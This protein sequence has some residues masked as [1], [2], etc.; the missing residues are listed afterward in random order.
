MKK[1][2]GLL[3]VLNPFY[4]EVAQRHY[5]RG[6]CLFEVLLAIRNRFKPFVEITADA[7]DQ[8]ED[9][10]E[11]LVEAGSDSNMIIDHLMEVKVN[12]SACGRPDDFKEIMRRIHDFSTEANVEEVYKHV[13]RTWFLDTADK[14]AFKYANAGVLDPPIIIEPKGLPITFEVPQTNTSS[15]NA[16][17]IARIALMLINAGR[18][19]RGMR[20]LEVAER[21]AKASHHT[22]AE[23]AVDDGQFPHN[24]TFALCQCAIG[25]VW[26]KRAQHDKAV[27]YFHRALLH[28]RSSNA[29]NE[30]SSPSPPPPLDLGNSSTG[31]LVD[32]DA[33]ADAAAEDERIQFMA[34]ARGATYNYSNYAEVAD[35]A[36]THIDLVNIHRRRL[37]FTTA[38]RWLRRLVELLKHA[39]TKKIKETASFASTTKIKKRESTLLMSPLKELHSISPRR[40]SVSSLASPFLV[41]EEDSSLRTPT[42]SNSRIAQ[43]VLEKAV[44]N[45]NAAYGRLNRDQGELK[46]AIKDLKTAKQLKKHV[47]GSAKDHPSISAVDIQLGRAYTSSWLFSKA[48]RCLQSA[49]KET[50]NVLGNDDPQFGAALLALGEAYYMIGFWEYALKRVESAVDVLSSDYCKHIRTQGG[51]PTSAP[52]T[53]APSGRP[54]SAVNT[55]AGETANPKLAFAYGLLGAV[56][57]RMS[58]ST[59]DLGINTLEEKALPATKQAHCSGN[60]NGEN[61]P[62]V[63]RIYGFIGQGYCKRALSKMKFGNNL[64]EGLADILKAVDFHLKDK[65]IKDKT[66]PSP[67]HVGF[68]DTYTSLQLTYYEAAQTIAEQQRNG[69]I[70]VLEGSRH[71]QQ[72]LDEALKFGELAEKVWRTVNGKIKDTSQPLKQT[73]E[74]LKQAS[75]PSRAASEPLPG[76]AAESAASAL[77]PS[78]AP[79]MMAVAESEMVVHPNELHSGEDHSTSGEFWDIHQDALTPVYEVLGAIHNMRGD[80]DSYCSALEKLEKAEKHLDSSFHDAIKF[81]YILPNGSDAPI[82][83]QGDGGAGAGAGTAPE[84]SESEE[85][86]DE[87]Q[88]RRLLKEQALPRRLN[89]LSRVCQHLERAYRGLGGLAKRNSHE[90]Q[91][92]ADEKARKVKAILHGVKSIDAVLKKE[93]E[94]HRFKLDGRY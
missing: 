68:L 41:L 43:T 33:D 54:I 64:E 67:M 40:G 12:K 8:F 53:I 20:H 72:M 75:E 17:Q 50:K 77:H 29:R 80:Y 25:K 70:G 87:S 15:D 49:A 6:W 31:K 69:K 9:E 59:V 65:A 91:K 58:D 76:A 89:R 55:T 63:A 83:D 10:V 22:D 74:P 56:Q 37:D 45:S 7:V 44:A 51:R 48:I 14:I 88:W 86:P 21:L 62:A 3:I 2:G 73:S 47:V 30:A 28:Y 71:R 78:K 11:R 61:H 66:L 36:D 38:N 92:K 93:H 27:R 82:R 39:E 52:S 57:V 19:N 46:Q 4:V 35:I 26:A 60:L 1:C 23:P 42:L 18:I 16:A 85:P 94:T 5:R 13:L 34:I 90:Y 81:G 24:T 32:Q 84:G 79:S